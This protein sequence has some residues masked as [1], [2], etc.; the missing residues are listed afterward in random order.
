[1]SCREGIR[2]DDVKEFCKTRNPVP[3][4]LDKCVVFDCNDTKSKEYGEND[5]ASEPLQNDGIY[6]TVLNFQL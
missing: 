3:K 1:M 6:G 4:I 5:G 2:P